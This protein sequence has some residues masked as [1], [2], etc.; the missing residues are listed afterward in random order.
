MHGGEIHVG[1][2]IGE[3]SDELDEC[4]IEAPIGIYHKGKRI[5]PGE[6]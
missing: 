4:N 3:L 1:G 5:W 2:E 6:E